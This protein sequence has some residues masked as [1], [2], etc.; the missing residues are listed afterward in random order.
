VIASFELVLVALIVWGIW[1][2]CRPRADFVVR[3][4][5]GVPRVTRGRVARGFVQEIGEVCRRHDVRRG[6]VRGVAEGRRISLSFSGDLPEACRQQLRNLWNLS[7]WSASVR[8]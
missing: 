5:L 7:G 4:R 8:N 6:E 1:M 2:A 3:I